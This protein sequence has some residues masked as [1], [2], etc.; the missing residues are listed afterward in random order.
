MARPLRRWPPEPR[1][2]RARAV[3]RCRLQRKGFRE[4]GAADRSDRLCRSAARDGQD[5]RAAR[6]ESRAGS[7]GGAARR[8]AGSGLPMPHPWPAGARHGWRT[9]TLWSVVP[10]GTGRRED[11]AP[12]ARRLP[13]AI[14]LLEGVAEFREHQHRLANAIQKPEQQALLRLAPRRVVRRRDDGGEP[15]A[16]PAGILQTR[17]CEDG[18]RRL[19]RGILLRFVVRERQGRLVFKSAAWAR[20]RAGRAGG[21]RRQ[22][23]SRRST[24][25]VS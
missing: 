10:P 22:R 13:H 12:R 20:L 6:N 24:T 1:A 9:R 21:G 16:L 2:A 23:A 14:Q 18:V 19:I 3:R 25:P 4:P 5:S 17:R 8:D 11:A 7:R 15:T